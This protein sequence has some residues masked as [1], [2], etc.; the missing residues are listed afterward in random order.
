MT[1]RGINRGIGR[2]ALL[3]D[4]EIECLR[5]LVEGKSAADAGTILGLSPRTVKF[6]LENV[7][8]KLDCQTTVQA[9]AAA[10]RKGLI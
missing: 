4:R 7:R 8:R 9:A 10:V 5:W 6:H 2:S 1:A 3:S